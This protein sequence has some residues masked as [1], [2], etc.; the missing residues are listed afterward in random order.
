M[1]TVESKAPT[2]I[3]GVRPPY[4]LWM[5]VT[6][7]NDCPLVSFIPNLKWRSCT[8]ICW[9]FEANTRSASRVSTTFLKPIRLLGYDVS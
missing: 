3:E 9:K 8:I 4:S 6:N 5:A 7:Y 1:W 2:Y